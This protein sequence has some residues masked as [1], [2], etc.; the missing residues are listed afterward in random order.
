MGAAAVAVWEASVR[1]IEIPVGAIGRANEG[2]RLALDAA[3][4]CPAPVKAR[5]D[6]RDRHLLRA[7]RRSW[8]RWPLPLHGASEVATDHGVSR[9]VLEAAFVAVALA[10]E[11]GDH[12]ATAVLLRP[13]A[14][15]PV[16]HRGTADLLL[17]SD[18][19]PDGVAA[20]VSDL[21]AARATAGVTAVN[22]LTNYALQTLEETNV[23]L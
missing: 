20:Y 9:I 22:D 5:G 16:G 19:K 17:L 2:A 4:D 3:E 7:E 1:D 13:P 23:D 21:A 11:R 18:E 14:G 12:K 6:P 10:A 15:G 8:C